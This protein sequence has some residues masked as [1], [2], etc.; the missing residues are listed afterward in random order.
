MGVDVW[1]LGLGDFLGGV[2][3]RNALIC[4]LLVMSSIVS[5]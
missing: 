2:L 1:L 4:C 3:C 5:M